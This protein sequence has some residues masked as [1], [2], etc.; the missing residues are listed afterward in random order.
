MTMKRHLIYIIGI[1]ASVF[2]ACEN[3]SEDERFLD[4]EGVTAQRVVL[5]EDY[6][7]QACSNCPNAHDVAA[8]LHEEYHDNLIV[9]AIHAGPQAFPAPMGLKTVVGDE[10]ANNARVQS[11]PSGCINRRGGLKDYPLWKTSVYD[12]IQRESPLALQVQS[13]CNNGELFINTE[14]LAL[15]NVTGKLQLWILEDS[16]V[17]FQL[18][19]SGGANTAYIHNHVFRSAINGTWGEDVSLVLG[20]QKMLEHK[21]FTIDAE[22]KPENLS[23]VAF[24]YNDNG[25]LQAAKCKVIM[26][27]NNN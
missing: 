19:P 4:I 17:G 23:V 12:E 18:L 9:V 24:V 7:G 25:V 8:E 14:I 22:W 27:N 10:Y 26:N 15:E 21:G 11:Y 3:I 20:D 5:L 6:T 1:V 13:S 16:I 2:T